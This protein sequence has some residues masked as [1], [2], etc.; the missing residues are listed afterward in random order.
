MH[1]ITKTFAALALAIGATALAG[2]NASADVLYSN[3]PTGANGDCV[4][5]TACGAGFTSTI[6]YGGQQ[7]SLS[8]SSTITGL[9]F[10]SI[11]MGG[12]GYSA[13]NWQVLT[14]DGAGG[15]PGT[16]IASGTV[17]NVSPVGS[18]GG[19]GF[20]SDF[21]DFAVTPFSVGAGSYTVAFNAVTTNT[22][23]YLS[24]PG[25]DTTNQS[26]ESDDGGTTWFFGYGSTTGLNVGDSAAVEVDG[27]VPEPAS[28]ALLAA[29]LSGLG[30]V[31]RR[32]TA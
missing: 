29:G 23:Q 6:T 25:F 31:R 12:S 17:N 3:L 28:L 7:F 20:S 9:G 21:Y 8:G 5:N 32:K 19:S 15:L 18:V 30:F 11:D 14:N 10:Y 22:A 13:V 2:S 16:L 24:D 1:K 27:T 4:F 26:V